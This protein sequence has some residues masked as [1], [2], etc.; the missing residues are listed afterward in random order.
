MRV[1]IINLNNSLCNGS[2]DLLKFY[3]RKSLLSMLCATI[4]TPIVYVYIYMG[5]IGLVCAKIA[6][7]FMDIYLTSNNRK[8]MC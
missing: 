4:S 3:I 7:L 5:F 1:N 8:H 2:M 6:C